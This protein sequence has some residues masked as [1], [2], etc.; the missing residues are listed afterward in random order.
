MLLE[1]VLGGA[2]ELAAALQNLAR[3]LPSATQRGASDSTALLRDYIIAD[4][5]SGNPLM[6]RSGALRRSI[7]TRVSTEGNEVVGVIGTAIKYA[8]IQEFG[9][10]IRARNVANLTIPLAAALGPDGAAPFTARQL[11]ENPTIG[12]F[13]RT[14]F[15]N[16][17]LF[18]VARGGVPTPL[19]KLQ[20]EAEL[21]ARSFFGAALEERTAEILAVFGERIAEIL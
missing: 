6:P 12:G 8:R 14:F 15:R 7:A 3:N 5:L 11:I 21:P 20:P 9:G 18:G 19:F 17:I 2:S 16:H 4:K 1:V 10:T 13:V